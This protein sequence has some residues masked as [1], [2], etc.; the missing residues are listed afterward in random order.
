VRDVPASGITAEARKLS[1]RQGLF[2]ISRD[3]K[4]KS[5]NGAEERLV[6]GGGK[7]ELVTIIGNESIK[8]LRGN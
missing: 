7:A 5:R 6:G 4:K 8:K 3:R 2:R 1:N